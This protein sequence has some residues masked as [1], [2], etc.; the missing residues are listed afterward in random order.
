[1]ENKFRVEGIEKIRAIPRN[2]EKETYR[3]KFQKDRDKILYSKAFRRLAGKT[4]V[5]L[6]END[7]HVRTRLTHTLEVA[8]I[9]K[10]ISEALGFDV[11]LT[12]AIALGHDIGHAP[13]G[14]VGER[15]LNEIMNGCYVIE[16][17][18][19]EIN[20]E[21]RGFKHNLQGVRVLKKLEE[22]E[23]KISEETLA[24]IAMHSSMNYEK[25]KKYLSVG[26]R[27]TSPKRKELCK[28]E[29]KTSVEFYDVESIKKYWTFEGFIVAISD[30]I[31]QRH[32]DIEDAL[33]FKIMRRDEF[34]KDFS[35][36]FKLE[37][38]R[39]SSNKKI[40]SIIIE[41]FIEDVIKTSKDN[42]ESFIKTAQINNEK[43]FENRKEEFFYAGSKRYIRNII[44]FSDEKKDIDKELKA[45]LKNKVLLSFEA[46][47]MDGKG[48]YIIRNI[49]KAYLENPQQLPNK[50]IE[51][52]Y[53]LYLG[54]KYLKSDKMSV[55]RLRERL[56]NDHI[57]KSESDSDYRGKLMRVICDYIAGMTDEY[58]MKEYKK[59]YN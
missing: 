44:S 58:A 4:Q 28:L 41:K 35:E 57:S 18:N 38:E 9:A 10:T 43:D 39:M 50:T 48:K 25:C 6:S 19:I 45:Y 56:Q 42:L 51:S 8:Q 11:N 5:F 2:N 29:G 7:D 40:A 47:R 52:F 21:C 32:H 49:F 15:I 12:E 26:Q 55:G 3:N 54:N 22:E 46:Q 37:E 30:E 31:A 59:L 1:M 16:E 24:G 27:C 23:L 33:E 14:H 17:Y 34:E 36:I 20:K 13:F 53:K